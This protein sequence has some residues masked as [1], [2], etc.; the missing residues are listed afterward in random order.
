VTQNMKITQ[1]TNIRTEIKESRK[2]SKNNCFKLCYGP[3]KCQNNAWNCVTDQSN[4]R[5]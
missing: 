5:I 2:H 3:I 4:V 1:H